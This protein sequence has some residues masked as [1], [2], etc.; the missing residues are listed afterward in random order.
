MTMLLLLHWGDKKKGSYVERHHMEPSNMSAS[1]PTHP[2]LKMPLFLLQYPSCLPVLNIPLFFYSYSM[3]FFHASLITIIHI[4]CMYFLGCNYFSCCLRLKSVWSRPLKKIWFC[5][6][7]IHEW[8]LWINHFTFG[9]PFGTPW[10]WN[11]H[12]Y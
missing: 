6:F 4:Y 12:N 5:H 1:W 3:D 10:R 7:T 9:N 11:L 8:N 2:L